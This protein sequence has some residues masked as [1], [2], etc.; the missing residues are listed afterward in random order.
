MR[1]A[2]DTRRRRSQKFCNGVS[3]RISHVFVISSRWV[4]YLH[5]FLD[6]VLVFE[7]NFMDKDEV[8]NVIRNYNKCIEGI[9]QH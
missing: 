5:V 2:A 9:K 7:R 8:Y 3:T 4:L 1:V 6:D